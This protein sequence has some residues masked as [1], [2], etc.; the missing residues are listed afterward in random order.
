MA[1]GIDRKASY[2]TKKT[3]LK[4]PPTEQIHDAARLF[5]ANEAIDRKVDHVPPRAI[6]IF[7]P[8]RALSKPSAGSRLMPPNRASSGRPSRGTVGRAI[9]CDGA[10]LFRF[11]LEEFLS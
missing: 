9:H 5:S 4:K 6:K 11:L 2:P 10:K 8:T 7:S 3:E 1:L